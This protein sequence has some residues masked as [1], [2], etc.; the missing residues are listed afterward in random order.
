MAKKK[1]AN[2]KSFEIGMKKLQLKRIRVQTVAQASI[3]MFFIYLLL[4]FIG[5]MKDLFSLREFVVL[6]IMATM[7]LFIATNPYMNAIK[8]EI[9]FLE[10]HN[11]KSK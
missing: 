8:E 9:D 3:F 2:N 10:N 11:K 4:G 6:L 5:I 1:K 7:I